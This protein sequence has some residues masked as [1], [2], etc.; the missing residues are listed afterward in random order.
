MAKQLVIDKNILHGTNS[1]ILSDFAGKYN[2]IIPDN[3]CIECLISES[4]TSTKKGKE[5]KLLLDRIVKVIKAGCKFGYSFYKLFQAEK[6]TLCPVKSVVDEIS[7]Q[8]IRNGTINIDINSVKQEAEF[9]R[10]SYEPEIKLLLELAEK[11]YKN[12]IKKGLSKDF[13]KETNKADRLNKWIQ[14]TDSRMKD[15][16]NHLF[17]DKI[18]SHADS[19]W[20]TWQRTR[21][22]FVYGLE[23][24]CKRNQSGPSYTNHNI[25]NDFYDIEYVAY[26]SRVNG[27]LTGERKDNLVQLL[28]KAAFPDKDVFSSLEEVPEDYKYDWA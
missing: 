28:A 8:K 21:L 5:P 10:M 15:I 13:R 12:L 25:S 2:I 19:D 22:W 3:L 27:L 14:T 18:S 20:I 26:L 11:F 6:V 16:M 4:N 1:N 9:C 24:A 17:S 7:T 23:W